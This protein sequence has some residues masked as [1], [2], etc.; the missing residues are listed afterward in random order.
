MSKINDFRRIE[1]ELAALLQEQDRLKQSDRFQAELEFDS[2]LRD[3]MDEFALP[4]EV[5]IAIVRDR[6]LA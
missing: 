2:K 5:V 6:Q 1:R 3:L 4:L